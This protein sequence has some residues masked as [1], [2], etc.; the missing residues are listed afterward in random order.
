MKDIILFPI[1]LIVGLVVFIF[2][3]EIRQKIIMRVKEEL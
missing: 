1:Y 3:K 2:V